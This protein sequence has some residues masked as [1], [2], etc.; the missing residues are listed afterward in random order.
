MFIYK[1]VTLKEIFDP[2]EYVNQMTTLE[3]DKLN[4]RNADQAIKHNTWE[5]IFEI[6]IKKT[7]IGYVKIYKD[8]ENRKA[9]INGIYILP[10]YRQKGYAT[11]TMI[12]VLY[13]VFFYFSMHKFETSVFGFNKQSY[14]LQK[15]YLVFESERKESLF[16]RG[17]FYSKYYFRLLRKEYADLMFKYKINI[18][19]IK[20]L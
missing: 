10:K 5:S 13:Y 12:L 7:N 9:Y 20:V 18:K 1:D 6:F 11:K 16:H 3:R 2:S 15:K 4:I 17:K 19:D 8:L 14:N